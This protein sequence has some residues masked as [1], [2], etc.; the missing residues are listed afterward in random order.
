MRGTER[1]KPVGTVLRY[2]RIGAFK[3]VQHTY[4]Q[5]AKKD[6]HAHSWLHL[7]VGHGSARGSV[8]F[9]G[10]FPSCAN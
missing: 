4:P 7:S 10:G 3:F 6:G 9:M 8:E 2:S 1:D 5:A